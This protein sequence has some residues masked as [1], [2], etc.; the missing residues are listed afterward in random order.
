MN[1]KRSLKPARPGN[2]PAAASFR[3][4]FDDLERMREQMLGRLRLLGQFSRGHPS[5][6]RAQAL[7]NESFRRAP[8]AQRLAI[9]QAADWL[10]N[11]IEQSSGL[12]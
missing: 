7:L 2:A 1:R 11:L 10:L 6:K 5:F 3:R 9:L 4:R 12:I 8:L